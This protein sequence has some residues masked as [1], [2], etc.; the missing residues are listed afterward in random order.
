MHAAIIRQIKDLGYSV[1]VHEMK[2]G[3]S[4]RGFVERLEEEAEAVGTRQ[5]AAVQEEAHG[6]RL[7]TVHA[8]NTGATSA[9]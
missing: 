2:G 6:V 1:S 4:F 5:A 8:A 7:V 3:I 9:K